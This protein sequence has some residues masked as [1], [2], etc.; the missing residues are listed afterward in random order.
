LCRAR[1]QERAY[2]PIHPQ[3]NGFVERRN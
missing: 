1:H 2:C 3:Q